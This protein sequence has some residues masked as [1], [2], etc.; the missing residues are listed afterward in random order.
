MYHKIYT[1]KK[2]VCAQLQK[3]K[4]HKFCLTNFHTL[5]IIIHVCKIFLA[6]TIASIKKKNFNAQFKNL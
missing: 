1:N 3:N 6:D 4:E 2:P 5:L